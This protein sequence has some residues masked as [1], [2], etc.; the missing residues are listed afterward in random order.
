MIYFWRTVSHLDFLELPGRTSSEW[1]C[2][3]AINW[4][5][6]CSRDPL[7]VSGWTLNTIYWTCFPPKIHRDRSC[8]LSRVSLQLLLLTSPGKANTNRTQ[9]NICAPAAPMQQAFAPCN[10]CLPSLLIQMRSKV[11]DNSLFESCRIT[12]TSKEEAGKTMQC[13]EFSKPFPLQW[14]VLLHPWA[15][16]HSELFLY[17]KRVSWSLLHALHKHPG[18]LETGPFF[19]TNLRNIKHVCKVKVC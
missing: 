7:S 11:Q 4:L 19:H 2:L 16:Y 10:G 15:I 13:H 9:P 1:H 17:C 3:H 5:A 12:Q 8:A 18:G 6:V 14:L